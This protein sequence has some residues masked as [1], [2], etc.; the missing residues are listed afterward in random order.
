MPS[1]GKF[2]VHSGPKIFFANFCSNNNDRGKKDN[3][4]V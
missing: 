2:I 1:S 4:S 3:Q